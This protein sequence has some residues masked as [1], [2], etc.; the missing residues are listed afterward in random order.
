ML[1]VELFGVARLQAQAW[2]HKYQLT[3]TVDKGDN[4]LTELAPVITAVWPG[5]DQQLE[6]P[7]PPCVAFA[8]A[9][10][11]GD[12]GNTYCSHGRRGVIA[13]YSTC[14]GKVITVVPGPDPESYCS[15]I[16]P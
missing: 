6:L 7:V 15:D 8:L 12:I 13:Y 10:C 5:G 3:F 16:A 1:P 4:R 2:G 9:L 11:D 14:T